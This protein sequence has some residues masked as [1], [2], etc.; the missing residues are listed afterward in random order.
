MCMRVV[1]VVLLTMVAEV[2]AALAFDGS[3]VVEPAA[4]GPRGLGRLYVVLTRDVSRLAVLHARP[5][6]APL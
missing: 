3:A 6:P 4:T 2:G 5:L 1:R